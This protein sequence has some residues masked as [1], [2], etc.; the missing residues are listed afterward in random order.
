MSAP[1]IKVDVQ[2]EFL[3]RQ[4][5]PTES[6]YAFAYHITISNSGENA[7]Q[8]IS[9]HWIITD[10]N[11]GKQEVHGMGVVG[12]QPFISPGESYQYSSGVVLNTPIGTM[13][14]TYQMIDVSGQP[15][16]ATIAPFLLAT[17]NSVH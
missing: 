11:Q 8:L 17:P 5:T 9:R 16:D 4:S 3:E 7:A 2:T 10:G 15:F 14:G 12:E 6:R 1:S 13:Q